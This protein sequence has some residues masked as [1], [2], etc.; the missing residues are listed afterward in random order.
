MSGITDFILH[1]ALESIRRMKFGAS[2]TFQEQSSM[3][4]ANVI[5]PLSIGDI[6]VEVIKKRKKTVT[7]YVLPPDGKVRVT[8]P[9]RASQ[10]GV[11][12]QNQYIN[13]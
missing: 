8:A 4:M 11:S 12:P 5:F 13:T 7:L 1:R 2:G 9:L 10:T 3:A 6:E